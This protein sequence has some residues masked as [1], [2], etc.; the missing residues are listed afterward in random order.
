PPSGGG[1]GLLADL[2]SR[3]D[4][5]N[6]AHADLFLS[7]H[8]DAMP[9][10]T[11]IGSQTIYGRAASETWA[12]DVYHALLDGMGHGGTGLHFR[13]NIKVT[14]YTDMPATLAELGFLD[15]EVDAVK[16]VDPSFRQR[17]AEILFHAFECYYDGTD[18]TSLRLTPNFP[19]IPDQPTPVSTVPMD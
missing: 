1:G 2:I 16:L 4:I 10:H 15:N 9:N 18:Y 8:C 11:G 19:A 12:R 6:R 17:E 5:A 14:E 7:I 13:P 3:A